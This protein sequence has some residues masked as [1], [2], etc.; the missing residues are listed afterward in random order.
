[1]LSCYKERSILGGFLGFLILFCTQTEALEGHNKKIAYILQKA[2]TYVESNVSSQANGS[3]EPLSWYRVKS[4]KVTEDGAPWV[5]IVLQDPRSTT[6][7]EQRYLVIRDELSSENP[8][9]ILD[10]LS[11]KSWPESTKAKILEGTIDLAMTE[12]QL[13]LAWGDPTKIEQEVI[14]QAGLKNKAKKYCYGSYVVYV[15]NG[16]VAR[17]P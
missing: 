16:I 7:V 15:V 8:Q 4:T 13:K 14:D 5:E 2:P 10:I 3:L 17:I 1:M 11:K 9:K 6:W 12:E